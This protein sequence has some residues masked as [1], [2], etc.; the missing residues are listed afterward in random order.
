MGSLNIASRPMMKMAMDSTPAKMGR[1]MNNEKSSYVASEKGFIR[2]RGYVVR[3][4]AGRSCLPSACFT[5][6]VSDDAHS[7]TDMRH[8]VDD[9]FF[10]DGQSGAG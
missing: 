2:N 3:F 9:D 6:S 5:T 1:L 10:T 8:A 4:S 7:G